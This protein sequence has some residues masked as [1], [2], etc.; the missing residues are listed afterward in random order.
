MRY[1]CIV[2]SEL[3]MVAFHRYHV[4]VYVAAAL[5]GSTVRVADSSTVIVARP[6]GCRHSR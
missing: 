2:N 3:F 4:T 5:D 6:M 1:R